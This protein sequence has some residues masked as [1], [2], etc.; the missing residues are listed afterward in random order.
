MAEEKAAEAAVAPAAAATGELLLVDHLVKDFAV[1]P[2]RYS[3]ARWA[4]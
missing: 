4:R 2:G 1:T 3:S